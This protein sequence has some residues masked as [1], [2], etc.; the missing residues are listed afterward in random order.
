MNK[1]FKSKAIRAHKTQDFFPKVQYH[2][3]AYVFIEVSSQ[4]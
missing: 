4:P 3:Y 1:N 2:K